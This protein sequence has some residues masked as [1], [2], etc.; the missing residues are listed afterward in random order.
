MQ[1]AKSPQYL[2]TEPN[3]FDILQFGP[4]WEGPNAL[5]S[6]QTPRVHHSARRCDD[7]VAARG[8]A[9]TPIGRTRKMRCDCTNNGSHEVPPF[10]TSGPFRWAADEEIEQN[11]LEPHGVPGERA[12]VF[13]G[14]QWDEPRARSIPSRRRRPTSFGRRTVRSSSRPRAWGQRASI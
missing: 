5:R 10:V 11:L 4:S 13:L 3:Q 9:Q 6:I 8:R 1:V 12:Q 7:G 14:E 2:L